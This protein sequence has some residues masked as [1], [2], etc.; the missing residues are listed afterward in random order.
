MVMTRDRMKDHKE[1][2]AVTL[3]SIVPESFHPGARPGRWAGQYNHSSID[4]ILLIVVF[5]FSTYTDNTTTTIKQK[6]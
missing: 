2:F 3:L 4:I 1:V 6:H 5:A